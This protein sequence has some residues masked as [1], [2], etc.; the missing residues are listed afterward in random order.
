[1]KRFSRCEFDHFHDRDSGTVFEK[2]VFDR[3]TFSNCAV[4]ITRNPSLRSTVRHVTLKDCVAGR[5]TSPECAI[6]EECLI[7]NLET[8]ELL[9]S[10]GA[11]FKHVTLRGRIGRIMLSDRAI[12]MP[13]NAQQEAALHAFFELNAAYYANLDWAL[14]I[15][16]AE[17]KECDIRGIPARLVRRDAETQVV[18]TR[19][20]AITREWESLD[21]TK[22][23]WATTI[24]FM[25]ERGDED[26]VLVAPKR[27]SNFRVLLAGIDALRKAGFAESD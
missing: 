20:K 1:M 11:V 2:L 14:D 25:L 7:E 15:S 26:V 18:V 4:S 5:W 27:A 3:C 10:W 8:T 9:Q 23:H 12:L 17:F 19:E 21:L 22:T 16:E 13:K 6:V 24:S